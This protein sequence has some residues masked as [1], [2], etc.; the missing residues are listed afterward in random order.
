MTEKINQ[1]PII[2]KYFELMIKIGF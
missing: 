1:D 2:L